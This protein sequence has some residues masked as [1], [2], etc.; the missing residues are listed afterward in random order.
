M[1]AYT[2]SAKSST[3]TVEHGEGVLLA[4]RVLWLKMEWCLL[5]V[6][7]RFARFKPMNSSEIVMDKN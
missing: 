7:V 5:Y 6:D 3:I 4:S 1:A 2:G